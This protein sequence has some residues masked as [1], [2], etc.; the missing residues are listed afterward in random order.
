MTPTVSLSKNS[1]SRRSLSKRAQ[2]EEG[3]LSDE[4]VYSTAKTLNKMR[5]FNSLKIGIFKERYF[6]QEEKYKKELSQLKSIHDVNAVKT[7][8]EIVL[9]K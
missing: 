2:P 1:E 9:R 3:G 6:R 7:E 5:V 4:D 8:K